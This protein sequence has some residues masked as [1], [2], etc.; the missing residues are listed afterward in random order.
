MSMDHVVCLDAI[1]LEPDKLIRPR[2]KRQIDKKLFS[3]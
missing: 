2:K 3:E 1:G